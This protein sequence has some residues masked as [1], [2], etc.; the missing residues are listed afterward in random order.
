M[1]KKPRNQHV[2]IE[3]EMSVLDQQLDAELIDVVSRF[4]ERF[5]ASVQQ[6]IN[7]NP[8][9]LRWVTEA[10]LVLEF[11][12]QPYPW[13]QAVYRQ[14]SRYPTN[15]AY[16]SLV[17]ED[18]LLVQMSPGPEGHSIRAYFREK[19]RR[20]A[21]GGYTPGLRTWS[22]TLYSFDRVLDKAAFYINY[23]NKANVDKQFQA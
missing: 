16:T 8:T 2:K 3:Q 20:A 19:G 14:R 22:A 18:R 13:A 9:K 12:T 15:V 5:I 7:V 4:G 17:Y 6:L 21:N 23:L 10:E 11:P 1:P